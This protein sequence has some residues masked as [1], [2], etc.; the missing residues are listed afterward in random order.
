VD[1][2]D[3]DILNQS[4]WYADTDNDSFGNAAT[5]T[6][7]CTQP[8]GFVAD[9]S[10]CDDGNAAIYPGALEVC[11]GLDDDCDSL[12]DDDDPD[13]LDQT[14]WYIDADSDGYGDTT[15]TTLACTQPSGFVADASDCDD[16]NASIN[17]IAVED[18]N[19]VD[20]DCNGIVDDVEEVIDTWYADTDGDGYG[21]PLVSVVSTTQPSGYVANDLDCDDTD[22][23]IRPDAV[24]T[25]GTATDEDCNSS[26]DGCAVS[27][28]N[29]ISGPILTGATLGDSLG[30]SNL[31]EDI[32]QDGFADLLINQGI[33]TNNDSV[34]LFHGPIE[35]GIA[36]SD[37][38]A[39]FLP[40]DTG[41]VV[42]PFLPGD[43]N[44]DGEQDIAVSEALYSDSYTNQGALR[45]FT[46]AKEGTITE[47]NASLT[48]L[49]SNTNAYVQGVVSLG[50]LNQDGFDDMVVNSQ[51]YSVGGAA[52]L[53]YGG[54]T[55]VVPFDQAAVLLTGVTDDQLGEGYTGESG[56]MDGD[57]LNDLMVG[58]PNKSTGIYSHN[59]CAY[60][61]SAAQLGSGAI[62]T[63]ASATICG[64]ESMYGGVGYSG[65]FV[66]DTNGDGYDDLVLA[67][68]YANNSGFYGA[69]NGAVWLFQG[70]VIGSLTTGNANATINGY[71]EGDYITR[72]NGRWGEDMD[73][74]GYSDLLISAGEYLNAQGMIGL[75]YGP[76]SGSYTNRSA[77]AAWYGAANSEVI[78]G[79][80]LST[81]D[82]NADG[83]PD[84]SIFG[85]HDRSSNYGAL[86]L[87][88]GT[89]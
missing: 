6:L 39:T 42:Y 75:F 4:S 49:G 35:P 43:F 81:G 29:A 13:I 2:A 44:G 34:L 21:D 60:I 65:G 41:G 38:V 63:V 53:F 9:S 20:D 7:A 55:G 18:C 45:V 66:G 85:A 33:Y 37:A 32:N 84:I 61:V 36:L 52:G 19:L 5:T 58:A 57:G 79:G 11:N 59:G 25:C 27:G 70:P 48:V 50:D 76:L 69:G 12:M 3:P 71:D 88:Y 17:P 56:D 24:E 1:D 62:S 89:P 10:D 73:L 51:G 83:Y 14:L 82:I 26:T 47:A 64:Q 54:Q 31:L 16:S 15:T 80:A 78:G 87:V 23:T 40:A 67:T 28:F 72:T 22:S 46:C 30:F 77:A 68:P 86:Y 74:D 8:T